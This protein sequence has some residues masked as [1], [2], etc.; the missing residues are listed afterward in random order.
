MDFIKNNLCGLKIGEVLVIFLGLC[1]WEKGEVWSSREKPKLLKKI[2][3]I[4]ISFH[5]LNRVEFEGTFFHFIRNRDL[6][7]VMF[8]N[9]LNIYIWLQEYCFAYQHYI[10]SCIHPVF[11]SDLYI[12]AGFRLNKQDCAGNFA[13]MKFTTVLLYA[14][15]WWNALPQDCNWAWNIGWVFCLL[16]HRSG[17]KFIIYKDIIIS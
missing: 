11:I 9:T 2:K 17:I 3:R 4:K 13:K 15:K 14:R 8:E 5:K 6:E 12:I 1:F 10:K 16:I 7:R